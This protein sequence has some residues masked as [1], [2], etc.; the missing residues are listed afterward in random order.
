MAEFILKDAKGKEQIFDHDKIFVMGTNGELVQF[1]EGYG[2]VNLQDKTITENGT[3][4]ADSGFDGLGSVSVEVESSGGF[5]PKFSRNII[6]ISTSK[7]NLRVD[8]NFGFDPDIIIICPYGTL[9]SN[10]EAYVIVYGISKKLANLVEQT[11][12]IGIIGVYSSGTVT[13]SSSNCIDDTDNAYL[14]N[15][16][17]SGF[18]LGNN[19][20]IKSG[21]YEIT[22]I[23]L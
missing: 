11:G 17:S 8:V 18:T 6:T 3:Y 23:G 16:N 9:S 20:A 7:I 13:K 10:P 4:T 2:E 22:A 19:Y 21:K 15:V 5:A 1:A 12:R 14:Y